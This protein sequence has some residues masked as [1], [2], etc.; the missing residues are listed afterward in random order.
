M[1]K[2]KHDNKINIFRRSVLAALAL[3]SSYVS[4]GSLKNRDSN[5]VVGARKNSRLGVTDS[6]ALACSFLGCAVLA[7]SPILDDDRLVSA[8]FKATSRADIYFSPQ[9]G[10]KP[11][12]WKTRS[13]LADWSDPKSSELVSKN[14]QHSNDLLRF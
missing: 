12:A 10:S 1:R 13:T 9:V 11:P 4:I 2:I 14:S 7:G 6:N 8:C 5:G 3:F